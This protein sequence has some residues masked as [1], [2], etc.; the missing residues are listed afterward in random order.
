MKLIPA[1][2]AILVVTCAYSGI[3]KMKH[4]MGVNIRG[5]KKSKVS[6]TYER[7]ASKKHSL[8]LIT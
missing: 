7:N 4:V 2:I 3:T 1:V 6:V 5:A 8:N